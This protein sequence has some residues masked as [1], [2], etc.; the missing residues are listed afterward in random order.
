MRYVMDIDPRWIG[1]GK[2]KQKSQSKRNGGPRE[3]LQYQPKDISNVECYYCGEKGHLQNRCSKLKGNLVNLKKSRKKIRGKANLED[4]EDSDANMI[5]EG[6]VFLAKSVKERVDDSIKGQNSWVLDSA[7][8]MHICKGKSSFDT[9][10]SHG[11]CG[12]IIVG[13]IKKLKNNAIRI[14]NVKYVPSASV[15][16]ISLGELT[17]HGYKYIGVHK[18]CKLYKGNRRFSKER[19]LFGVGNY[20]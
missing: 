5:D 4:E 13:N 17:S 18:L 20:R 3:R 10:H 12:Y 14:H 6:D 19:K 15:D 11:D 1:G 7:A 2:R 8:F 9:L 16:L